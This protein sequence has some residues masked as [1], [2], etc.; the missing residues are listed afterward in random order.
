MGPNRIDDKSAGLLLLLLIILVIFVLK[1]LLAPAGGAEIPCPEPFFVQIDGDVRRPGV[2]PFCSQ[3]SLN[4]LIQKA[5]GL[6]SG[7]HESPADRSLRNGMKV[8]FR[9]DGQRHEVLESDISAFY[10]ITLGI[11]ISLNRESEEGLTAIPGIGERLARAIAAERARRGG[12]K[13]LDDLTSVPGI[14]PKL[15]ARIKPYLIL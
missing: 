9:S 13:K 7:S 6:G 5:G 8:T 14:G 1:P 12:F 11:P 3:P 10:K 15:Y 2:Y 4:D